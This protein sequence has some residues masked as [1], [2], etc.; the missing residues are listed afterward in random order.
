MAAKPTGAQVSEALDFTHV[1]NIQK[2]PL[3]P[4][5]TALA[6]CILAKT[7]SKD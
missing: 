4:K 6:R 7:S 3:T 2:Q 1:L 5:A